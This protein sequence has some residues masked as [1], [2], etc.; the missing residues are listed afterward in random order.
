[1]FGDKLLTINDKKLLTFVFRHDI[2]KHEKKL[3]GGF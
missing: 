2:I 3:Y 1:M